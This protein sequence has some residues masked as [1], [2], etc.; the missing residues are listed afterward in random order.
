MAKIMLIQVRNQAL[1]TFLAG[2][3]SFRIFGITI[4][5]RHAHDNE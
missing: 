5:I 2:K 1:R 4:T 3:R